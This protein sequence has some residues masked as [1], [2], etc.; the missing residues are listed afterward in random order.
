M[1]NQNKKQIDSK[2]VLALQKRFKGNPVYFAKQVLGI[3]SLWS[4]QIE[5]LE[6]IRDYSKVT[7]RSGHS[8]GK[9]Y[10]AA[11]AVEWWLASNYPSKVITTAPTNNQV[12]KVLW[13]EIRTM[14]KKAKRPLGGT[15]L[16][17]EL[18][19]NDEWH[20]LGF[21]TDV[22]DNFQGFKSPNLLV[23]LDEASGVDPKIYEAV[24]GLRPKC[25]LCIGNPLNPV[26]AFADTF[27]SNRW[28]QKS[29][30]S[31]DTPNARTG[32][33]IVPGLATR[34]WCQ[35]MLEK[36]GADDPRYHYRVLGQFPTQ[37][38]FQLISFADVEQAMNTPINIIN[39]RK[40]IG[41]DVAR[42]GDDRSVIVFFDGINVRKHRTLNGKSTVEIVGNVVEMMRNEWGW[43]NATICV[44]DTGVGGGVTDMLKEQGYAVIPIIAGSKANDAVKYY[45][46]R[47]EMF[48]MLA[49]KFKTGQIS[50]PN[51]Q[52]WLAD[53]VKLEYEFAPRGQLK[54]TSKKDMKAK[55]IASTDIADA[56]AIA[57]YG[58][59]KKV[60]TRQKVKKHRY[61]PLLSRPYVSKV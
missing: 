55:G 27:K 57:N 46:V 50:I 18:R 33:N 22:M 53:L 39:E 16:S 60:V 38:E 36:W 40:V 17:T 25:I 26:G 44:D 23:I 9:T 31:W 1:P 19:Y 5:I 3:D 59:T 4:K 49:E 24:E 34:E 12:E 61:V 42:F 32:Q 29:V 7:V 51:D 43:N 8:I 20:A 37:S 6:A 13:R 35:E 2:A 45:N 21:S 47:A 14:H 54:I 30:S 58:S 56:L 28:H 52:D 48:F 41:V 15:L 10:L 11:V